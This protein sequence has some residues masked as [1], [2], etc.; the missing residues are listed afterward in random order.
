M[1]EEQEEKRPVAHKRAIEMLTE[2][3]LFYLS[4]LLELYAPGTV[5]PVKDIPE[6]IT[7]FWK[8]SSE[9]EIKFKEVLVALEGQ[10]KEAKKKERKERKKE[11]IPS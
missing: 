11:T 7:T 9:V 1:A 5:V 2:N 3:P 10:M 4:T 8:A 6:L